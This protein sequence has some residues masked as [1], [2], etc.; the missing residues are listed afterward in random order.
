MYLRVLA[1]VLLDTAGRGPVKCSHPVHSAP[2]MKH[3]NVREKQAESSVSRL[4]IT[5]V[6]PGS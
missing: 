1:I 5:R 4:I 3:R 6:P 2:E